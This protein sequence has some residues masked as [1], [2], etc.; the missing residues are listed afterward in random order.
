MEGVKRTN[1]TN[2]DEYKYVYSIFI[3]A[4]A[5]IYAGI[6]S[7]IFINDKL[8]EHNK[9]FNAQYASNYYYYY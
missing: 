8:C 5:I 4:M 3:F 7:S 1:T 9:N 2:I 6:P